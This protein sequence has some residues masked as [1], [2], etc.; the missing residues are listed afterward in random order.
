MDNGFDRAVLVLNGGT[1]AAALELGRQEPLTLPPPP[2]RQGC[3]GYAPDPISEKKK[4]NR[5]SAHGGVLV[6]DFSWLF[7]RT[8]VFDP[9]SSLRNVHIEALRI[10]PNRALCGSPD[11]TRNNVK[12]PHANCFG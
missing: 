12:N 8:Q 2:P 5:A 9:K 7:I 11:T 6:F 3:R 1:S 10:F 4:E